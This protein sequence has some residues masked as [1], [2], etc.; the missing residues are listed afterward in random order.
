M[1]F[2]TTTGMVSLPS[3]KCASAACQE[4][5]RYSPAMSETSMDV[6]KD[7]R[8]VDPAGGRLA[9]EGMRRD[10]A[11]LGFYTTNGDD[12]TGLEGNFVSETL[13][14]GDRLGNVGL[15]QPVCAKVSLVVATTMQEAT[16]R[17]RPQDGMVGLSLRGLSIEPH[18]NVLHCL[19][20]EGLDSQ[21]GFFV[22]DDASTAELVFGGHDRTRLESALSWVPVAVP[23][24][25][26]WLVDILGVQVGGKRLDMCRGKGSCRGMIDTSSPGITMPESL[27][28]QLMD[29]ILPGRPEGAAT[30]CSLP[31]LGLE[32]EGGVTLTLR[33]EDYAGPRCEPEIRTHRF[34]EDIVGAGLFLLGEPVLR[35]YYTVFDWGAER[36]GFGMAKVERSCQRLSAVGLPASSCTGPVEDLEDAVVL[37]AEP[38]DYDLRMRTET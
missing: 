21:F 20:K 5:H 33:V 28:D 2:S 36:L 24:L 35:R 23:E 34:G 25:G 17:T 18:F 15:P 16:F 27:S 7:G 19:S 29:L 8:P 14:V 31:D 9:P 4:H 22:S 10:T 37:L 6:Q 32:L 1:A 11:S 26:H 30:G 3:S 13:C 38:E 12:T